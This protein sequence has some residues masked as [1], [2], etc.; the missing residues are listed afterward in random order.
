M[1]GV[2]IPESPYGVFR[3]EAFPFTIEAIRDLGTPDETVVWSIEVPDAGVVDIPKPRDGVRVAVRFR[4]ATGDVWTY[5]A[6]P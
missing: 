4:F 2:T 1:S 5:P 6:P 3:P